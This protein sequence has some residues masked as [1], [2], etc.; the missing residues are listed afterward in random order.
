MKKKYFKISNLLLG[1]LISLLG[2]SCCKTK[3][4]ADVECLYGPP[5]GYEEEI[6]RLE[7]ERLE[8]ERQEFERQEQERLE[9]ER[10]VKLL[11]EQ[12][13]REAENMKLV[14]GPPPARQREKLYSPDQDNVY[15]VVEQMPQFPG[16]Q[17]ALEAW[18]DSHQQKQDAEGRV[19]VSFI[20][21]PD[22]SLN[23]LS[24]KKSVSEQLDKEAL[25]LLRQMPKWEPGRHQGKAVRVRFVLPVTFRN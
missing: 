16:G 22:G 4:H 6:Q 18:L 8:Q 25:R 11:E 12:K 1:S 23:G 9:Y 3:Q 10:Q 5:P 7:Q 24:V 15:D 14:Y 19:I 13:R 17:Q 2:F 20:V 21:E